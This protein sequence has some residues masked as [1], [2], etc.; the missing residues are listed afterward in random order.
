MSTRANDIRNQPAY[1]PAEA[2]RYL[3][4]PIATLRSW[5]VGRAYPKA[6]GQ[7]ILSARETFGPGRVHVVPGRVQRVQRPSRNVL[8]ELEAERH[9]NASGGQRDDSFAG[10]FGGVADRRA[11]V[12]GLQGRVFSQNGFCR[13]AGSQVV[14]HDRNRD[15]R[16]AEADGAMHHLGVGADQVFPVHG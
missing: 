10:Q 2:A 6:D 11:N 4:L 7:A 15:A 1:G 3:R 16:A 5:V 8:V 14:Q 13:F 12:W 9:V